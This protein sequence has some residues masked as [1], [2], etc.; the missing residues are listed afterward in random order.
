MNLT[1]VPTADLVSEL[2]TRYNEALFIGYNTSGVSINGRPPAPSP[3]IDVNSKLSDGPHGSPLGAILDTIL[4]KLKAKRP[5][6]KSHKG[7]VT[8]P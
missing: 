3:L 7:V 4:T 6:K 8:P 2:L 1:G 5:K